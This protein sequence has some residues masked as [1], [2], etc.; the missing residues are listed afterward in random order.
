M[1]LSWTALARPVNQDLSTTLMS[2]L[3]ANV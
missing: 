3:F 2:N 1:K